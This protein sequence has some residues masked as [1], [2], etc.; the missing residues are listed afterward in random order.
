MSGK[1]FERHYFLVMLYKKI[2]IIK[3]QL[4]MHLLF[5]W[6]ANHQIKHVR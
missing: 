3:Y 1:G 6:A 4:P 5:M 2:Y